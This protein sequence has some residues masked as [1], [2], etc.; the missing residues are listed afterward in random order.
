MIDRYGLS[1]DPLNKL[2][3]KRWNI[4]YSEIAEDHLDATHYMID[5]DLNDNIEAFRLFGFKLK[6]K[7]SKR[8][9]QAIDAAMERFSDMFRNLHG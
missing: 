2:N 6:N 1:Y 9:N 8:I 7:R 3:K 4:A 5:Q